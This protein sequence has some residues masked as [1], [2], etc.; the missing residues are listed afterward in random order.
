MCLTPELLTVA[1]YPWDLA[2]AESPQYPRSPRGPA[3][4]H[5]PGKKTVWKT[6]STKIFFGRTSGFLAIRR[7]A[8]IE[9]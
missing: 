6:E 3:R 7:E 5:A 9:S 2:I 1:K 4:G 8:I